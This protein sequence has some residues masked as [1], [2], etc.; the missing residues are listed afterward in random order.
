MSRL[1]E[2]ASEP[3]LA[4]VEEA[5]GTCSLALEPPYLAGGAAMKEGRR[6]TPRPTAARS[7]VSCQTFHEEHVDHDR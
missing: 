2:G 3:C 6:T 7:R 4:V 5:K 1:D